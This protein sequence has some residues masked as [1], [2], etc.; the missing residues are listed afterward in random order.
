MAEFPLHPC[1]SKA[2][3]ASEE[4]GCTSEILSIVAMLQVQ[5]VFSTPSNRKGTADKAK[6]KFT[7]T[8]GDHLTLLNIYK[9]FVKKFNKKQRNLSQW[10]GNNYLNYK[11]LV[12]AVQ[13]RAQLATLLKKFKIDCKASCDDR[14]EPILKCLTVAFFMNVAKAHYS[15]SYKHLKSGNMSFFEEI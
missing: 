6:L 3:L 9:T 7:C 4:F 1:H 5:H 8:E 13:I 10:C 12:R 14:S 15:G 2:L 11:S